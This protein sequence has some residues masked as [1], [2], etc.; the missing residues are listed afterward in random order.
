MNNKRKMVQ[1][2]IQMH[3]QFGKHS[4]LDWNLCGVDKA[5]HVDQANLKPNLLPLQSKRWGY[6]SVPPSLAPIS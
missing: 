3:Y 1:E 6:K 2:T 4:I 5:F